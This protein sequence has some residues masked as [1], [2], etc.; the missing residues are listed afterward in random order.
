[1]VKFHGTLSKETVFFRYFGQQKLELRIAH[2]RLTRICFIDYDREMA[3]V[4]VRQEL[5]MKELEITGVGRLVK[6]HGVPD[7]EFAIE[8]KGS[9]LAFCS[10]LLRSAGKKG[11]SV[12]SGLSCPKTTA[13]SNSP[14]KL[15]LPWLLIV[16][17]QSIG[18]N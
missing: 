3:L 7:A 9:E 12:F 11:L 13:C 17:R 5:E 1:M 14:R 8:G 10:C 2:E 6:R 15:V 4:A 18:P 16:W